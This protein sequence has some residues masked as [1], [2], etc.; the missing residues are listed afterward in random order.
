MRK[1]ALLWLL[2]LT[3][4]ALPI[5]AQAAGTCGTMRMPAVALREVSRGFSSG[6]AGVDLMAAWGSPIRAA[7]GG[8]VVYA[9]WYFA[10]GRIVDIQHADGVVTRYAHMADFAP[11]IA[12]G[13]P[14]TAGEVIGRV[15][16]TGR[17]HGAHVH[18]EVRIG[19]RAVDPKPYL[20]LGPCIDRPAE[21]V[22]EV[23]MAPDPQPRPTR[24]RKKR[25]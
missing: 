12:A 15:G 2:V 24:A 8:T 19:G 7:D 9:G 1:R 4:A 18:F 6:H 23:A 25:H 5:G 11:G 10:Y 16:A 13:A 17:A 20:A 21:E 22:L 14:V 3:P